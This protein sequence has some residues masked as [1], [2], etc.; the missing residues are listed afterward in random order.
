MDLGLPH[1][2]RTRHI[3]CRWLWS[4]WCSKISDTLHNVYIYSKLWCNNLLPIRVGSW[5]D[6]SR[7]NV[8]FHHSGYR[9]RRSCIASSSIGDNCNCNFYR[10][11]P[12]R[13]RVCPHYGRSARNL[14]QHDFV[15][16]SIGAVC[17]SPAHFSRQF[18][19]HSCST[20]HSNNIKFL[21]SNQ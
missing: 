6:T 2:Y 9:S 10:F 1:Y 5:G 19:S 20:F 4:C 8:V 11:F 21:F 14:M 18:G 15:S 17:N 3:M 16:F 12:R 13:Y 7:Q